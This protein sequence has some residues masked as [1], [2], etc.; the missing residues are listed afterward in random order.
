M[1]W[2]AKPGC[3]DHHRAAVERMVNALP[4][5]WLLEPETGEEFDDLDHCNCRMRGHALANGYDIVR[6]GGGTKAN[7]TYR[8]RCIFHGTET[9]NSRKL[10]DHV[11]YDDEG[12]ITTKR[13][14]ERTNVRQLNCPWAAI[15]S[16]KDVGKR[17]SGDKRYILTVQNGTHSCQPAD[18]PFS[19]PAHLKASEEFKE[20]L[21]Q[22]KKH[23]QQILSYSES[24]RLIDAEDFSV[25]VSSRDYYN[26]VRKEVPDKS[27]SR[28]IDALLVMLEENSFVFRTRIS[29]EED[30]QGVAISRK[31]IQI[32]FAHRKQ[33][34]AAQRF[35]ADW[36]VVIDGTFN[37][38]KDRLPLLVVVGVLN[39]GQTF[40]VAFS[41]CPSESAESIEFVWESLKMECFTGDVPPPRVVLG[42]W[43]GG[44]I[45]SVPK[46]FPDSQYQGCDW[47]AVGAML[48]WYRGKNKNYT[49]EEIDGSSEEL[50]PGQT[51][52]DL[53]VPG[54]HHY[55]WMYIQSETLE[56]LEMNRAKLIS[57]LRPQDQHYIAEHWRQHEKSVVYYYTMV[58]PNL[59]STSSQRGE[60]YHPVIRQTTNSQLSFE[61]SGRRLTGK[62]LSILKELATHEYSSLRSYDRL[63][64]L[65]FAAFK[66]LACTI[67]NYALRKIEAE[68]IEMQQ[69]IDE[70]E[71][72]N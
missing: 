3:A 17:G 44:L 27:K 14:R 11:E 36:L 42:D 33:L 38:N 20:A 22:A 48:K 6:K 40:P 29:I 26:S 63:A 4:V 64:Q 7:P 16:Y 57:L 70:I 59:G 46:A 55:S 56:A 9:K 47:H 10:E 53:R 32:W 41:Y 51:K 43:A 60:S 67:S 62:I 34:E 71:G 37:T 13:Q 45:A 30:K 25:V 54:L 39:S 23:R 28:T 49:S 24:R 52:A 68:W 72:M 66:N 2:Q 18:D 50:Q 8:F 19:F 35:V 31:L 5:A 1:A 12:K 58:Y 65:D 15:C 21:H 61:N 69:V